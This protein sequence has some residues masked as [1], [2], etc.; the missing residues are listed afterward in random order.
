M[1]CNCPFPPRRRTGSGIG[2]SAGRVTTHQ[3]STSPAVQLPT[4]K[5][6][7]RK[8]AACPLHRQPPR[9][10]PAGLASETSL[11]A[12]V[13]GPLVRRHRDLG[14]R[15][16]SRARPERLPHGVAHRVGRQRVLLLLWDLSV[17]LLLLWDPSVVMLLCY[18]STTVLCW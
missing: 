14:R 6:H 8:H 10:W 9:G 16:S 3:L 1:R 2:I 7:E 18:N 11:L 17:M 15:G 13:D 5:K 12:V 4:K